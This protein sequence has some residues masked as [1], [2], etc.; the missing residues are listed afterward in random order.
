MLLLRSLLFQVWMYGL[1]GLLGVLFLPAAIWSRAGAYWAID[2]YLKLVFWGLR[3]IVGLVAV[4]LG[5]VPTGNVIIASKHQSFLDVL[6]LVRALP[7]PKFVM[8]RSLV[9]VPILGIYALRIGSSPVTRGKGKASVDELMK[10]VGKRHD[11]DGQLVIY[12]QGSRIVP[13]MDAPYKIGAHH[14][15][16][17][18]GLR[19]IPAAVNTGHFWPRVGLWRYPGVAVLEFLE[20]IEPGLGSETFLDNLR[21]RIEPASDALSLDAQ[22]RRKE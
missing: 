9:W 3:V 18:E 5:D 2:I 19:C 15:Y 13:G 8:K 4:V 21:D 10:E 22:R 20:P 12:P 1:M 6:I 17:A 14:I 11:L 7:R 16:R